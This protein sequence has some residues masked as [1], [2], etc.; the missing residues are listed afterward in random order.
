MKTLTCSWELLSYRWKVWP[1][2]WAEWCAV[3][4]HRGRKVKCYCVT[5]GRSIWQG[6]SFWS[7]NGH[8]F[9]WAQP[10]S[11]FIWG[12]MI[13]A[14]QWLLLLS[15]GGKSYRFIFHNRLEDAGWL[16][17]M[18]PDTL[19]GS[20]SCCFPPQT[21]WFIY[22]HGLS[23]CLFTSSPVTPSDRLIQNWGDF[24]TIPLMEV[25]SQ[26]QWPLTS[27]IKSV[28]MDKWTF[29]WTNVPET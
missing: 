12:L 23:S 27:Q 17:W 2:P 3:I 24:F 5:A 20:F 14:L 9:H 10:M 25:R 26:C 8:G 16:H 29:V 7:L 18:T 28:I 13:H 15:H 1:A 4:V 11:W 6:I 21:E 22:C 19:T